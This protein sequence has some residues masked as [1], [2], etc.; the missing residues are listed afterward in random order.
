MAVWPARPGMEKLKDMCDVA[1]KVI[2]Q[3]SLEIG[4]FRSARLAAQ[5][6]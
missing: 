5:Q 6:S 4:D 2:E 1:P 3:Y